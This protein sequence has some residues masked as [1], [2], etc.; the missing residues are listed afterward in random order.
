[1]LEEVLFVLSLLFHEVSHFI[2]LLR[3]EFSDVTYKVFIDDFIANGV[4]FMRGYAEFECVLIQD[5]LT[6]LVIPTRVLAWSILTQLF[7]Y[8]QFL[9]SYILI[10]FGS[11]KGR[12]RGLLVNWEVRSVEHA[13]LILNLRVIW[14]LAV[15][16][17]N[18]WLV[19]YVIFTHLIN[20]ALFLFYNN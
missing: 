7:L 18:H 11:W 19:H 5:S 20:K 4:E 9:L 17:K 6:C 15:P 12:N 8:L 2:Q 10:N 3:E 14:R 13:L 16:L 1:M